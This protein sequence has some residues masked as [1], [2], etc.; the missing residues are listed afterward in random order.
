[1]LKCIIVLSLVCVLLFAGCN[2][3]KESEPIVAKTTLEYN[4]L[5]LDYICHFLSNFVEKMYA[6]KSQ[7]DIDLAVANA[8]E[9][10]D[11]TAMF[12]FLISLPKEINKDSFVEIQQ[13][14]YNIKIEEDINIID[15][16]IIRFNLYLSKN[17][18]IPKY[19]RFD[20]DEN[21]IVTDIKWYSSMV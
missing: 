13:V 5:E 6:P 3:P 9:I 20:F 11:T 2:S 17:N 12:H 1:M 18:S 8:V 16:I 15:N 4:D 7:N 21:N 19:V 14:S 10:I